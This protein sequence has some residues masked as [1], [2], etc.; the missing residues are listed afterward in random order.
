[1]TISSQIN[2]DTLP[3]ILYKGSTYGKARKTPSPH[4]FQQ[5]QRGCG[6]VYS[7][8]VEVLFNA[9]TTGVTCG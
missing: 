5:S 2:S 6:S 9:T 3:T 7:N 4:S 8:R 1:M